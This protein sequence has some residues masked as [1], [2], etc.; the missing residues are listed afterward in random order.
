MDPLYPLTYKCAFCGEDNEI[1][2][3]LP[4]GGKLTLTE[5]CAVCCRPNNITLYLDSGGNI[6]IIVEFEG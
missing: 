4:A 3:D 6:S 5:D 2:V 1:L